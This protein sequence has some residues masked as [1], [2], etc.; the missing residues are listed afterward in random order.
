MEAKRC[1]GSRVY[2]KAHFARSESDAKRTFGSA[3]N[4][5]FVSKTVESVQ[6]GPVEDRSEEPSFSA[7]S[8]GNED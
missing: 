7:S 5:R 8:V 3:W 6:S 1:I 4:T 2:A